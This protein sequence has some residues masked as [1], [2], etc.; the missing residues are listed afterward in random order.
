MP[1]YKPPF[2]MLNKAP[3]EPRL[4]CANTHIW[5]A[6][7][8]RAAELS[9]SW[10]AA[11][12][13]LDKRS[14]GPVGAPRG[15][16]GSGGDRPHPALCG[17]QSSLAAACHL[18]QAWDADAD[19]ISYRGHALLLFPGPTPSENRGKQNK[20]RRQRRMQAGKEASERSSQSIP[21]LPRIYNV[22]KEKATNQAIT[23][24]KIVKNGTLLPSA[25]QMPGTIFSALHILTH[26]ILIMT[27][28][29]G[30]TIII[31]TLQ[32]RWLKHREVR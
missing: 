28:G 16:W 26:F 1:P 25:F 15:T 31:P 6:G 30:D 12:D 4:G 8:S 5:A 23:H 19:S 10:P 27:L 32:I 20:D 22:T 14:F 29:R 13:L 11:P 21:P 2:M 24:T 3:S 17:E 18:H 9:C 7:C